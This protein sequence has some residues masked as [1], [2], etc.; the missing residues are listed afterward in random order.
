MAR[1]SESAPFYS[2]IARIFDHPTKF[3]ENFV[4]FF[5]LSGICSITLIKYSL[6]AKLRCHANQE[7]SLMVPT[8]WQ[9]SLAAARGGDSAALGRLLHD[10]ESYLRHIAHHEIPGALHGKAEDMDLVQMTFLEATKD[11]AR[12]EGATADEWRVW[13]HG[14]LRHCIAHLRRDFNRQCRVVNREISLEGAF[15]RSGFTTGLAGHDSPPDEQL[16][17]Q[18]LLQTLTAVILQLPAH[19][20]RIIRLRAEEDLPYG[21]IAC[22]LG[23]TADAAQKLWTRAVGHLTHE[24]NHR[25]GRP[26]LSVGCRRPRPMS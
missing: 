15:F 10:I 4:K 8:Q 16:A 6:L 5:T 20:Q 24:M 9:S 1:G 12:F 7:R 18:E 17:K 25:F 14:I 11:F 3:N 26:T 22:K 13:V 19:Y 21:E 2:L 23:I